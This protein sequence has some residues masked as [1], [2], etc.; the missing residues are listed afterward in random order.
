MCVCAIRGGSVGGWA[1]TNL[2]SWDFPAS[3]LIISDLNSFFFV[4]KTCTSVLN[5]PVQLHRVFQKSASPIFFYMWSW[6][7]T[8]TNGY[9]QGLRSNLFQREKLFPHYKRGQEWATN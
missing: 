6:I 4:T 7:K 3:A 1:C 8:G 9:L 5:F 2:F